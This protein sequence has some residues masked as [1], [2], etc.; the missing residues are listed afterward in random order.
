MNRN[1]TVQSR[2]AVSL[3]KLS[4]HLADTTPYFHLQSH[5]AREVLQLIGFVS[6]ISYIHGE[7]RR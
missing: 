2:S 5:T 7:N 6:L 3:V 4:L 1:D